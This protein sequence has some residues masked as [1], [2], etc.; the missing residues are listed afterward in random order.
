MKIT[1]PLKQLKDAVEKASVAAL[2]QKAQDK[3]RKLTKPTDSCVR[4]SAS[5]DS[6]V[7]E[8]SSQGISA[9]HSVQTG[10]GV[11]VGQ[12][13]A[14]CV[15]AS[16][17]LR[18]LQALPKGCLIEISQE[19]KKGCVNES[20]ESKVI[21]PSG[22]ITT[23]A[24]ENKSEKR[25]GNDDTFPVDGFTQVDYAGGRV[26]FSIQAKLLTK[27]VDRVLFAI[28]SNDIAGLYDNVAILVFDNKILFVGTDGRKCAVYSVVADEKDC[29]TI[30][31]GQE[32]LVGGKLLKNS[33]KSFGNREIIDVI[34]CED[35]EHVILAGENTRV[36]LLMAPAK[37]K[38]QYPDAANLLNLACPVS[39]VVDRADLLEA[40]EVLS[41]RNPG[42]S[43]YHIK[44]GKSQIR[45]T[46][47]ARGDDP[48][49]DMATAECES[50]AASPTNPVALE[51]EFVVDGC[52]KIAGSKV[53]ISFSKDEKKIRMESPS[54]AR[55]VYFFQ[56]STAW[57]K[58]PIFKGRFAQVV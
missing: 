38:Q 46:T 20:P 4:V 6:I 50:I 17:Y 30:L 51:N 2:T 3:D 13:G 25:R 22:T 55:F 28:N 58:L 18:I 11:S 8:S 15:E 57:G 48:D 47:A 53:R 10:G 40:V 1:L 49:P 26:L 24:F 23:V 21:E 56:A 33:C 54:D 35:G 31:D 39:I 41:L 9:L 45:I 36:R 52:E 27:C 34:G 16:R 44:K 42:R 43:I 19:D 7:F 5:K 29:A 32:I 14:C 12:E 37:I